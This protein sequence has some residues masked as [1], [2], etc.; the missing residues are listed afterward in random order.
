MSKNKLRQTLQR[1]AKS[2]TTGVSSALVI[3]LLCLLT[4]LVGC[5]SRNEPPNPAAAKQLLKLRGY[6][7]DEKSF[8]RA[9]AS[10]DIISVNTFIAAGINPNAKDAE[11]GA[12]A[13]ISASTRG[14]LPVVQALLKG[15]A[16]VNEKDNFGFN[17]LLRAL[18]NK[19]EEVA[20]VLVARTETD[21]NARGPNGGTVLFQFV[22]RNETKI[23]QD[24]LTRGADPNLAD[25]EGDTPLHIAA[26]LG[27]LDI[28]K[29]LLDKGVNPNAKSKL[30]GT[31]LMW[32]GVFGHQEVAQALL[33]K[34]A[35]PKLK[36]NTGMTAAAW[37]L[38]NKRV[39]IAEFLLVAEK[40]STK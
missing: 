30:G 36:D 32:T 8:L 1:A 23:V 35:D 33:D 5:E 16:S 14:D 18:Q 9:A 19:R 15:N 37:A 17:A 12:T 22:A 27:N 13:L 31:P 11:T 39:G 29:M 26:Q 28:V 40:R 34:G 38:K 6:E 24:L 10:S 4:S 3:L 2:G 20:E 25:K 7:F 21:L